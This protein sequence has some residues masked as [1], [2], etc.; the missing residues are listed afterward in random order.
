MNHVVETTNKSAVDKNLP[1]TIFAY[2]WKNYKIT[3]NNFNILFFCK[4]K[5]CLFLTLVF[6]FL[7]I[8]LFGF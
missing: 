5:K 1:T 8:Q 6:L 4:L 2:A 7:F 3:K